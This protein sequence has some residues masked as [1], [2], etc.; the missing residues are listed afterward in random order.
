MS[1]DPFDLNRFVDAQTAVYETA[2]AEIREGR[3]RS[4][5]MWFIFP[6]LAGLGSSPTARHF[7]IRSRAEAEAYL[8][9]SLLGPRLLACA[10]AT[11][12]VA[13]RTAHDI[14]G[15]PDDMKLRSSA[16]LFAAVSESDSVFHRLIARY[17]GTPD[18]RTLDLLSHP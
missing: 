15:H 14:F 8:R 10:N 13:D 12:D 17:F 7:A 1:D 11:L 3:K 5:W 18:E 9:H 4:H 16:T 2:V 6:Q